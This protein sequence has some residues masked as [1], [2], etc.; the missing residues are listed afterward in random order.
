MSGGFERTVA[1]HGADERAQAR[2]QRFAGP[3]GTSKRVVR[4]QKGRPEEMPGRPVEAC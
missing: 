4:N 3:S 2:R 1:R